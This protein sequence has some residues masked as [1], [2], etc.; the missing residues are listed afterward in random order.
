MTLSSFFIAT[1]IALGSLDAMAATP[2]L[3]VAGDALFRDAPPLA[4]TALGGS[5]FMLL[6]SRAATAAPGA[7]I[8]EEAAPEAPDTQIVAA[9]IAG[10]L[11]MGF[12][13]SRR[14]A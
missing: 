3:R 7:F 11:A 13:A 6:A 5:S 12:L 1:G 10:C 14:A 9:L 2:T 4:G 8:G